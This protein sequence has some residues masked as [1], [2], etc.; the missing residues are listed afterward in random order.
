MTAWYLGHSFIP[1]I[2]GSCLSARGGVMRQISLVLVLLLSA[3]AGF[4]QTVLATV[5]GTITDS[6]GADVAN[7]PVT[8]KNVESGQVYE[9]ASSDTGNFT[10]S[11]APIGDYDLTVTAPGFKTYTHTKF[12][13]A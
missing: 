5:T 6:T 13:L 12:H 4:G 2:V 7:A 9:A 11:Q 1:A 3:A 8:L 10:V